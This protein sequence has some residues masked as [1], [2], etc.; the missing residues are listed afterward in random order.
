[1]MNNW[2]NT[3]D[4]KII[5]QY[6]NGLEDPKD[7][8]TPIER[9][10]LFSQG[11][12][13]DR[14]PCCLSTGETMAP[15]LNM[16]IDAYYH[17]AEMMCQLEEYLFENFRSDEAGLSTT[18]RGMAEA[19]G[20]EI[21]YYD[22]NIAQLKKPALTLQDI[23]SAKLVDVDKD[24]RLPIILEGLRLVKERLGDKV[25]ISATV[26]GP[27]SVAAMVLGTEN[28]LKGMIKK[29]DKIRQLMEV[30]AENNNRYIQRL[31]DM[32]I[33]IG[34]ADP[35]SS[36]ALI[37]PRH[38]EQFSLPYFQKNVDFIKSQGA[39]CGLHICGTSRKLWDML[40]ETGISG[41]S[42]DNVESLTEAKEVLGSHMC[43]Q[44]NVPPVEVMHGGTPWDVLRS[45][46]DCIDQG[47]DSPKGFVLTSGCQ[48]PP[49]TPR[50]NMQALMDAARIF[51]R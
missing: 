47:R 19:M 27:F 36:T 15:L 40:K 6:L 24:G 20:S 7:E 28:L 18:L 49:H 12:E 38:Y 11:K 45:A 26:T 31:I 30:I 51:G 48:M 22:H 42:L 23:D 1:M 25:P 43:I 21:K 5:E 35:V 3:A 41:F 14:L 39:G 16:S 34:F 8:L 2:K 29:P 13:V 17:S 46:K 32:E 50:E 37:S 10:T 33:G 9:M 44:G 4:E